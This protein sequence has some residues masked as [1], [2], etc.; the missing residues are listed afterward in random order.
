[1]KAN[2]LSELFPD[3]IDNVLDIGC[4]LAIE[5]GLLNKKFGCKLFLLDGDYDDS[6]GNRHKD[7]GSSS[8]MKF[9]LSSDIL[10][11]KWQERG[12]DYFFINAKA[13]VIQKKLNSILYIQESL[14]DF[15]TL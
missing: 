1:M 15:T 6:T 7:Y 12:L 11:Q 13:P 2:V 8:S 14:V 9:Y 10:Q 5:S 4:G 3:G